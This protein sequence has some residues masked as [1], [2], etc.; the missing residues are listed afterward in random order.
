MAWRPSGTPT[1]LVQ[2]SLVV[3]D[4]SGGSDHGP[5]PYLTIVPGE[6][7]EAARSKVDMWAGLFTRAATPDIPTIA[8][9]RALLALFILAFTNRGGKQTYLLGVAS[10]SPDFDTLAMPSTFR[11]SI[12]DASFVPAQ[13]EDL[14]LL[15]DAVKATVAAGISA[16]FGL[17]LTPIQTY[18]A[19]KV[20]SLVMDDGLRLSV[21]P[22]FWWTIGKTARG[23]L[24]ASPGILWDVIGWGCQRTT[25]RAALKVGLCGFTVTQLRLGNGEL[26]ADG[27]LLLSHVRT[28]SKMGTNLGTCGGRLLT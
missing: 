6:R 20:A 21:C 18:N 4:D 11:P 14:T 1:W 27:L 22:R 23:V 19:A 9:L 12:L 13:G 25:L 2:A 28:L 24:L 16:T 7:D 17:I 15:H 10:L 5:Q 26:A 3:D 8:R